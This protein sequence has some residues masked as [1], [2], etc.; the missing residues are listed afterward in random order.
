MQFPKFVLL[1]RNVLFI[2]ATS[3]CSERAFSAAGDTVSEHRT[4]L[5]PKTIDS[6]LFVHSNMGN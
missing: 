4:R 1:A 2:P 5:N 3:A 6:I